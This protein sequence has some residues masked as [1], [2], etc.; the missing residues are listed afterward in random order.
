MSLLS[1]LKFVGKKTEKK[2]DEGSGK[3]AAPKGM[4]MR[5]SMDWMTGPIDLLGR[6][7]EVRQG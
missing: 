4:E 6:K 5:A 3:G 2:E 1:G 7:K